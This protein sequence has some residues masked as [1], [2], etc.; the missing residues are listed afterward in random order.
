MKPC[1]SDR[2]IKIIHQ[3]LPR[4]QHQVRTLHSLRNSS[5]YWYE[6]MRN[7][8]EQATKGFK[9]KISDL[10]NV[11]KKDNYSP[12][13]PEAELD[14][15]QF[16][17]GLFARTIPAAEV[18]AKY[19]ASLKPTI[20]E[21]EVIKQSNLMSIPLKPKDFQR[22]MHKKEMEEYNQAKRQFAHCLHTKNASGMTLKS[23]G[24]TYFMEKPQ[25]FPSS[26]LY[27]V[28]GLKTDLLKVRMPHKK[29]VD[30]VYRVPD[31]D[32]QYTKRATKEIY[33][34]P[35]RLRKYPD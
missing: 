27:E 34:T 12:K 22:L 13:D 19:R 25:F 14:N 15:G 30:L 18:S 33:F 3:N 10:L 7:S 2:K 35:K 24:I 9:R 28:P 1:L 20:G 11:V 17:I 32:Y 26:D 16:R 6:V 23:D 4:L 8:R 31:P 29:A 5:Y 21:S